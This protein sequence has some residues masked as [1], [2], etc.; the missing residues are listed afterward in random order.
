MTPTEVSTLMKA[1]AGEVRPFVANALQP[2]LQTV[3]EHGDKLLTLEQ[4]IAEIPAGKDGADGINGKDGAPGERGDVGAVGEPGQPGRDGVDGKD[5]DPEVS[6]VI[7]AEAVTEF[8][9]GFSKAL[10]AR[11]ADA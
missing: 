8:V 7:A 1:V 10:A 9:E 5:A 6:R 11:F 4:R 3:N 2:V